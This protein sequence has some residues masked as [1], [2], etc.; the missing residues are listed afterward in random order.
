VWEKIEEVFNEDDL[1]SSWQKRNPNYPSSDYEF[2]LN[3]SEFNPP[4]NK[5]RPLY[6]NK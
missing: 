1:R 3:C 2:L 4:L 5:E 6:K